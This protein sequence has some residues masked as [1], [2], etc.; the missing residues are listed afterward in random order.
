MSHFLITMLNVI[1]LSVVVL[2]VIILSVVVLNVI[3]LSVVMLNAITLNVVA[4]PNDSKQC[5]LNC[6]TQPPS[7]MLF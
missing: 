4:P 1:M 6:N 7:M 2:N 5:L 3:M